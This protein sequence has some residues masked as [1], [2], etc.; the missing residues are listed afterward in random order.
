MPAHAQPRFG[1]AKVAMIFSSKT[2][3]RWLGP[4]LSGCRGHQHGIQNLW[5][6][7]SDDLTRRCG[8]GSLSRA[9]EYVRHGSLY[10]VD[11][12]VMA[13]RCRCSGR[14]V[15]DGAKWT[16]TGTKYRVTEA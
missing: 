15:V 7:R 14:T 8:K 4:G 12:G 11:R 16:R 1:G 10:A 5:K 3:L 9:S 2:R 6:D 13:V